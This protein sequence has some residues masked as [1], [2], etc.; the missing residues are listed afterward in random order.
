MH[1]EVDLGA[2]TFVYGAEI[3]SYILNSTLGSR[4][5]MQF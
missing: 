2:N 3:I 5:K 1:L 4:L